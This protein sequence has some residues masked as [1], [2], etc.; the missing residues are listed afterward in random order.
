VAAQA[1]Q[2]HAARTVGGGGRPAD[3]E[4][5]CSVLGEL[6]SGAQVTLTVSRA[7]RGM[8]EQT[9]EAYGS[10]GAAVYRLVR[11]GPGWYRGELRVTRDGGALGRERARTGLPRSAGEGNQL[12][13][14]G[15]ATI[16]PLV[17]R[18]LGGIRRGVT[19]SP[20]FEDGMRAQA[21]LDAARDAAGRGEWVPV[22]GAPAEVRP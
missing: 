5:F 14:I 13:V 9:L 11:E 3:T 12:E 8:N 2:A 20:S 7:A 21:V 18:L 1:G 22:A 4:D 17:K 19:P 16:A 15:K 6:A 10:R